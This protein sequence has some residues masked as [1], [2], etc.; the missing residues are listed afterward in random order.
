MFGAPG[1]GLSEKQFVEAITNEET[2]YRLPEYVT[3]FLLARDIEMEFSNLDSKAFRDTVSLFTKETETL[4]IFW[5]SKEKTKT[6]GRTQS[7]S[8][9]HRT[10]SG[11]KIKI[12]GA[13][14]IGYYTQKLPK[15]PAGA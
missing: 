6:S 9:V 3:S 13:Q 10:T 5:Y 8:K 15:F 4:N 7:K 12:A 2:I 1:Q 11:L 14:V